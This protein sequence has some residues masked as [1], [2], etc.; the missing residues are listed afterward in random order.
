MRLDELFPR[1]F[2]IL[3]ICQDMR[4]V[5]E[6]LYREGSPI[7]LEPP[8]SRCPATTRATRQRTVGISH[9]RLIRRLD[10]I[11]PENLYESLRTEFLS[12]TAYSPTS[13]YSANLLIIAKNSSG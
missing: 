5:L 1:W 13:R 11:T 4:L 10:Y 9:N 8:P 3:H 12:I 2:D 7:K 6:I